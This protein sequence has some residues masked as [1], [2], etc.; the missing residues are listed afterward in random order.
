MLLA[1]ETKDEAERLDALRSLNL[2]DTKSEQRFDRICAITQLIFNAPTVAVSLVDHDRV[3]VKSGVGR[4]IKESPRDTSFCGHAICTKIT[5]SDHSRIMEVQNTLEDERFFNNPNVIHSPF[6]R[7]YVGFVLQTASKRNV[8]TLCIEDTR[9]RNLS[10]REK[11]IFVGLG[12]IVEA[13]INKDVKQLTSK[14]IENQSIF[15]LADRYENKLKEI[16]G[17]LKHERINYK[18]WKILNYV[19]ENGNP[20]PRDVAQVT[21]IS[22]P[23]LSNIVSRLE[24]KGLITRKHY[25]DGD[26][27]K[28]QLST[29]QKGTSIWKKTLNKLN[30]L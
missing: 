18:E 14:T 21:N 8:G 4:Y 24:T 2:L 3:W 5:N 30:E 10:T 9:K 20:I 11:E 6:V 7:Y 27:R 12:L 29:T 28:I 1:S 16:N 23:Q 17:L 19:I 26:R 13:E 25:K 15:E 22:K